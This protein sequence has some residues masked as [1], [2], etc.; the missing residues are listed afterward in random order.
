MNDHSA[1]A[2]LNHILRAPNSH[3]EDDLR[4]RLNIR[5]LLRLRTMLRP[6]AGDVVRLAAETMFYGTVQQE[7]AANA[8]LRLGRRAHHIEMYTTLLPSGKL[9][10]VT[11]F[12]GRYFTES[13]ATSADESEWI[14]S[15]SVELFIP[16]DEP[17]IGLF[18]RVYRGL[19]RT[20]TRD[21]DY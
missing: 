12:A 19:F 8:P 2:L 6:L 16:V 13:S 14:A 10:L 17:P 5:H 3:A 4:R 11:Y 20:L 21:M 9:H 18:W 7:Y 1:Q 15:E